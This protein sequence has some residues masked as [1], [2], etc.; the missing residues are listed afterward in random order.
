MPY[1]SAP[2]HRSHL[3]TPSLKKRNGYKSTS[4]R[5]CVKR[6]LSFPCAMVLAHRVSKTGKRAPTSMT[7]RNTRTN[8]V[9]KHRAAPQ[10]GLSAAPLLAHVPIPT[11]LTCTLLSTRGLIEWVRQKGRE[12]CARSSRSGGGRHCTG[13]TRVDLCKNQFGILH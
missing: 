7:V 2:A 13:T 12:P 1:V 10:V 6:C 11:D 4:V 3:P 8:Q 5:A 9:S